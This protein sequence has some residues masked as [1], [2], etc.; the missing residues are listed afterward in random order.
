MSYY[1]RVFILFL[2][3]ACDS[4]NQASS[5][6]TTPTNSQASDTLVYE[7]W[8]NMGTDMDEPEKSHVS[9]FAVRVNELSSGTLTIYLDSASSVDRGPSRRFLPADSVTVSGLTKLDKFTQGCT[10]GT[11]PWQPRIGV[12]RDS[13]YERP[14][15]PRFIWVLD[16]LHARIQALSTDSASCFIPGPE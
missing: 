10:Y 12:M 9:R 11:G 8:W 15:R 7:N 16:T 3:L 14:G 6:K 4:A 5:S 1:R 13:V 2:L